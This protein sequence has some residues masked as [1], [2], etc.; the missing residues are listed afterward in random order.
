MSFERFVNDSCFLAQINLSI[1]NLFFIFQ[2]VIAHPGRFSELPEIARNKFIEAGYPIILQCEISDPTAQVSWL[3]DGVE[4]L[5]DSGLDIQSE[6]TMRRMI[7]QSAELKNSGVY[8]CEAVDDRI[9]F[10]V[11]VA[12]D[13]ESTYILKTTNNVS[14]N[15][16]STKCCLPLSE[17]NK[18]NNHNQIIK[19]PLVKH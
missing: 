1:I 16:S 14:N 18:I 3:K 6:G 5:Q 12:G 7:I 19:A 9:A 8:S 11:D 10:R 13:F 2:I 4:L 15:A 17:F